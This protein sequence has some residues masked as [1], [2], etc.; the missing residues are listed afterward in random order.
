MLPVFSRSNTTHSAFPGT[1]GKALCNFPRLSKGD[2]ASFP[3]VSAEEGSPPTDVFGKSIASS[4][5]PGV[6]PPSPSAGIW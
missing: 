4:C 6:S 5:L 3:E 2:E 1:S